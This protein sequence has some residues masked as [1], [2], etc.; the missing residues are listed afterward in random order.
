MYS[1]F[2]SLLPHLTLVP[3]EVAVLAAH[4]LGHAVGEVAPGPSALAR[5]GV[6]VLLKESRGEVLDALS[7]GVGTETKMLSTCNLRVTR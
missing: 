2:L 1:L 6:P 4:G 7:L 3:L 5:H